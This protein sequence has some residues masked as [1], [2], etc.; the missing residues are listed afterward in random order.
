MGLSRVRFLLG[1]VVILAAL[2]LAQSQPLITIDNVMTAEELRVTGVEGLTAAQ[3]SA[4]DRWLSD[5]TL[6]VVKIAKSDDN[7]TGV[8]GSGATATYTGSGSG[9]WIRSTADDG[10]IVVLEDGSMWGL[11]L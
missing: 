6:K 8:I 9:H 2:A 3:R 7:G 10:A 5:Y 1:L 11:I 4:L